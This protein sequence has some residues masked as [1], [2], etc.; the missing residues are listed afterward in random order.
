MLFL[1]FGAGIRLKDLGAGHER[2]CPRCHNTA[3]WSR[4]RRFHELTLFFIPVARWGRQELEACPIC[5]QQHELAEPA[6]RRWSMR[7]AVT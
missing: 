3:A 2:T 5:G 7:H 6:R 1:L 4:V